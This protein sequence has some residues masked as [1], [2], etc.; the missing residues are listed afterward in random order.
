MK[1]RYVILSK[2]LPLTSKK[3]CKCQQQSSYIYVSS[4]LPKT[5][6]LSFLEACHVPVAFTTGTWHACVQISSKKKAFGSLYCSTYCM[7]G[8]EINSASPRSTILLKKDVCS[9]TMFSCR[10]ISHVFCFVL[11]S[12]WLKLKLQ[13]DIFIT[14]KINI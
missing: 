1:F 13:F 11:F 4:L 6:I 12:Y 2:K 5:S 14:N 7:F 8:N 10:Y 9:A 3:Y